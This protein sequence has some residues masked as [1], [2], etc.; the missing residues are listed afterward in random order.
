MNRIIQLS[1]LTLAAFPL[2]AADPKDEVLDAAKQLGEKPN[3]SWKATVVVPEGSQFRPGPTEGKTEKDGFTYVMMSFGDNLTEAVLKGGKAVVTNQEG[4]WETVS[5][6]DDG[7]GQGRF[8][9]RMFRNFKAPAAQ[10]ADLA[11]G[12]RDLKKE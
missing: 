9:S 7:G 5:E 4:N 10:A 6:A 2:L 8:R 1:T 3:Y 12:A 11:S